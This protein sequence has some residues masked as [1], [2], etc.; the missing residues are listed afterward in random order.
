V[1]YRVAM[2]DGSVRWLRSAGQ[3]ETDDTGKPLIMRGI[4]QDITIQKVAEA[5]VL[6]TKNRLQTTLDAIPDLLFEVGL[7]GRLH[8]YHANRADLLAAPPEVFLGKTVAEVLPADAT[9]VC[10]SAIQEAAIKGWSAGSTYS[11]KLPQGERWFELSIAP[12]PEVANQEQ[13][14]ILLTRDVTERKNAELTRESLEARLRESQKLEAI[15]TLAGGIAHDFNNILATILGNAELAREDVSTNLPALQSLD[16]IRK[17]GTRGRDLVQQILSF[18]RRQTAE[19]V[20]V[21]LAPIIEESVRLLRA[22]LPAR[23]SLISHSEAGVPA[24]LADTTQLQQI[25]INL[26]TNA[27]QAMRGRPGRIGIR[28]DAIVFDP[29]KPSENPWNTRSSGPVPQTSLNDSAKR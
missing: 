20:A 4:V 1:E 6:A 19:R 9:H 2:P 24:V 29:S 3:A 21:S 13:H 25:L 23:I 10:M 11:L 22:T 8:A 28:L 16:E 14:F 15:G 7:D 17:A 12:M 26:S 5:E 27:M 18:G